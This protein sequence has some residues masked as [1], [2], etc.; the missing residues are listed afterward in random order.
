[1][2][3]DPADLG[4]GEIGVDEQACP[5]PHQRPK[6]G[7]LQTAAF[8]RRA[9]ALPNDG[10]HDGAAGILF[11][12]DGSLPLVGDADS[13]D[14]RRSRAGAFIGLCQRHQLGPEDL[15]GVVLHPAGLGIVL[16]QGI[17]TH[18]A[19]GARPVKDNG[20]G[21]GGALIQCHHILHIFCLQSLTER[22][23]TVMI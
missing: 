10:V 2:V 22:E 20:P 16:G 5:L 18:A 17:L 7:L 19:D 23:K 13:G 8:L 15:H 1:M 4:A 12:D 11:P 6:P 3:Q 14:L 9:A 21:A